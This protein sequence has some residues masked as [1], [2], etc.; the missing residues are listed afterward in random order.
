MGK[1]I[2][3]DGP[4]G[5]GKSTISRLIAEKLGFQ[6]LD[7]GALYRAAALHLRRKGL[8]ENSSDEE[9][10]NALKHAEIVFTDGRVF[11]KDSSC[12]T[13]AESGCYG[14]D[15]SEEIRTTE[16]GHYASVF[17]AKDVVRKFLLQMQRDAAVHNDIVAEGRDMTTVV[18]PYAWKKFFLDASKKIRAKRRFLQLREKG[19]KITMKDALRDVVERDKR[20]RGRDIAPLKIA[21]DAVYIDTTDLGIE[22]VLGKILEE[23]KN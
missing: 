13:H 1:V 7:T 15:V 17:S 21:D 20:D 8:N 2:A 12:T 5:A 23:I 6:F 19:I 9:I 3:I 10:A 16:I 14:E 11:L 22:E 18:F 4:S